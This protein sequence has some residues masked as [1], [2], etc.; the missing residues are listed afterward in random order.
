LRSQMPGLGL[1]NFD[2]NPESP[3]IYEVTGANLRKLP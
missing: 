3:L 2:S 1:H